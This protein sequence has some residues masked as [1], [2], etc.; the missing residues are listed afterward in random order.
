MLFSYALNHTNTINFDLDSQN[1][2]SSLIKRFAIELNK[3]KKKIDCKK[4]KNNAKAA[5]S[6]SSKACNNSMPLDLYEG[7]S[8]FRK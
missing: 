1:K 2:S 7:S 4:Y 8:N 3:N 5:V 6:S